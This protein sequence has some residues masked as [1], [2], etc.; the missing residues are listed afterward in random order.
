VT[1]SAGTQRLDVGHVGKAHGL[2][3][4][5]NIRL[6][7]D[8]SE[9]V[10]PG[11]T[12]FV[13][14]RALVVISS[15]PHQKGWIVS[16]ESVT[17]RNQAE[18]LR[19]ETLSADRIDDPDA[20]WVHELIGAEL[21]EVDGTLRGQVESVQENP[22]SDLLVTDQGAL[23]PLTFVVERRDDGVIVVDVPAGLFELVE[24]DPGPADPQSP[25]D[26]PAD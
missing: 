4:D 22:A 26:V 5:L 25:D 9:R 20:L 2:K 19:G 11:A 21:E 3:G 24:V 17:D 1:D 12:L 6:T 13:N 14:D 16:F 7:T 23:V 8:R 18:A 15:R 10:D